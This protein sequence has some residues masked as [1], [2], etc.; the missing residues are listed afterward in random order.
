MGENPHVP[1]S[2]EEFLTDAAIV[3]DVKNGNR[4]L[5]GVIIKRYQSKLYNYLYRFAHER[6]A[7]ED[8]VSETF[9]KAYFNLQMCRNPERFASWLFAI[10]H[11]TGI[12]WWKQVSRDRER[13]VAIDDIKREIPDTSHLEIQRAME[14][15]EDA[16]LVEAALMQLEEKYRFPLLLFYYED[17][18]YEEISDILGISLNTVKTHLFR[19]KKRLVAAL[20]EL[21]QKGESSSAAVPRMLE[22]THTTPEAGV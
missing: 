19:A 17:F 14:R 10:G 11:N 3:E 13:M 7:C 12:N 22:R 5:F 21:E 4:Q 6:Q 1:A 20:A 2:R 8:L 16:A 15:K 18:S 9:I